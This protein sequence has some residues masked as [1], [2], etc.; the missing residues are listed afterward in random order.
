M[1]VDELRQKYLDYFATQNHVV[2]PSASLIPAN[3]PTTLFTSAGMQPMMPYLLGESHPEGRRIADSQKCFRTQDI[4]EVGDNRHTTFF[5]MLGNWSFGDYFK[6]EQ[7]PWVFTFV[8]K[9]LELDPNR[10]YVSC[11]QGNDKLGIAK[12]DEA[13]KLWVDAFGSVGVEARIGERI[14]FY[15]ERENWWSRSGKPD[16]MLEGEPGGP[17]SEMFWDFDPDGQMKLHENSEWANDECH[18]NCDCGRFLEIGNSVFMEYKKVKSGF[19]PLA[20][21]N[22]DFGGGLER[23]V[24]AVNDDPDVFNIDIFAAVKQELEEMSGAEYNNGDTS[25]HAFRVILDHLRAATFLIADGAVP[26]NKDQGYFTRRLIRR[27]VRYGSQLGIQGQFTAH[28]AELYIEAYRNSYPELLEFKGRIMNELEAEEN[29]FMKTLARGLQEFDKGLKG[30][31]GERA[32]FFFESHGFPLELFLE[33]LERREIK[34]DPKKI[35]KKFKA[36]FKKHQE[37]SRA[38]AEQKFKGGLADTGEMSVKYHTATHLLHEALR[39]VLGE[40]VEQRGSNITNER[41]RFDFSHPDKMTD[42]QK[43]EVEK[44]VNEAIAADLPVS[45]EEMS[46]DEA[47]NQGAIGLFGDKYGEKVKV[48]SVGDFSKEICGGPHVDHLGKLGHFKIN[49]EEASS[50]G[51][52]RIKAVLE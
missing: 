51:I 48:Y 31:L 42:E 7:I 36:E 18:T 44:L 25:N 3:D 52:R 33:E 34:H 21:K 4:N 29:K 40:H 10:L 30:E 20:N 45:C 39:R 5:E 24:A 15:G 14:R 28:L 9:V 19:E 6:A 12:D 23:L 37:I 38:G 41:L 13:A 16:A 2:V 26:S 22:I 11:Y 8:V 17:D 50:A 32:F 27:A 43:A 1:T 47:K 49:K 46:V 35:T